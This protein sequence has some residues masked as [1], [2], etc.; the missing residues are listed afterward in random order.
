MVRCC[1]QHI[2]FAFLPPQGIAVP[3][4]GLHRRPALAQFASTM[5][6]FLVAFHLAAGCILSC[7]ISARSR[8]CSRSFAT[9]D[10]I[11]QRVDRAAGCHQWCARCH[12]AAAGRSRHSSLAFS[13]R[14]LSQP[15]SVS[16]SG[17]KVSLVLDD[18]VLLAMSMRTEVA[19]SGGGTTATDTQ[20]PFMVT[21][22]D[23]SV[24]WR[25]FKGTNNSCSVRVR[26]ISRQFTSSRVLTFAA[27]MADSLAV[28]QQPL[29][30]TVGLP[31]SFPVYAPSSYNGAEAASCSGDAAASVVCSTRI[32]DAS[33]YAR[34]VNV[35]VTCKTAG[36]ARVKVS[37]LQAS[38]SFD[39]L[40]LV[41]LVI[42]RLVVHVRVGHFASLRAALTPPCVLAVDCPTAEW[43]CSA[44]DG[45]VSIAP[46]DSAAA[47]TFVVLMSL[48]PS[49]CMNN[50]TVKVYTHPLAVFA[51]PL[52][53]L[54]PSSDE[55]G[56]LL[57]SGHLFG[58]ISSELHLPFL[59]FNHRSRGHG[60]H[61]RSPPQRRLA[62]GAPVR[63]S[64]V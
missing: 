7:C 22:L 47:V 44:H 34:F 55:R 32:L 21:S 2:A 42:D 41:P 9:C 50:A 56:G 58:P 26:A 37:L 15:L 25:P 59:Y 35:T 12:R 23:I 11:G 6:R 36:S 3:V 14:T 38:V 61:C 24:P 20:V 40:C 17:A 60:L 46:P 54:P 64:T 48:G 27:A 57:A 45:G 33:A 29:Q 8:R 4:V 39:V 51:Q 18:V 19:C 30:F 49:S 53:L 1:L 62:A 52:L 16:T 28:I 31:G 43:S 13:I 63:D 5:R 10:V